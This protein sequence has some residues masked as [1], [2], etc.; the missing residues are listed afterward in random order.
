MRLVFMVEERSMKELLEII[1]PKI[2]SEAGMDKPLIIPHNGKSDLKKS[3]PIKLRAWKNP[4][5][6]FVIVYDQD[7][8]DCISLKNELS[9]L[10][11]G[12]KNKCLI[13]IACK[14]LESWYF[15]DLPA[16]SQAYGTDLIKLKNKRK[17]RTPDSIAN[18][19]EEL[20][21]L[22]PQHQQINGAKIIAPYMNIENNSSYSFNVFVKGIKKFAAC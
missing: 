3:I 17:Y 7:A 9:E 18:P 10:C 21:K 14:E 12:A 1:L 8:N 20:Y 4:D 5:D 2:L 16:L 11:S 22:L 13:R 15:G 6:R 19:K